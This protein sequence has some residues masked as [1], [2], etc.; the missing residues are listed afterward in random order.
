V[1]LA[2][3]QR[4]GVQALQRRGGV[5]LAPEGSASAQRLV[6]DDPERVDVGASVDRLALDLLGGD[7]LGRP[8]HEA[9]GGE[10]AAL[11][12]LRDAEVGDEHPAVR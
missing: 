3:P 12:C 1:D 9:L 2:G 10:V 8:D 6:E 11:G 4:D 5:G 7:V